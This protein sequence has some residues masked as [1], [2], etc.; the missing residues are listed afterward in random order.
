M[1]PDAKLKA[2]HTPDWNIVQDGNAISANT[3]YFVSVTYD[4]GTGEMILYKNGSEVDRATVSTTYRDITETGVLIGAIQQ[5]FTWYGMIDEARIYDRVLSAT[6]INALYSG[7]DLIVSGET[8]V[9]DEWQAH[10]TPFSSTEIG[11]TYQSNTI[12]IQEG[13]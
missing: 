1:D 11:A 2:G 5:T 3:W 8:S 9:G 13:F 6:Q 4:Y 7:G 12:T 10:V